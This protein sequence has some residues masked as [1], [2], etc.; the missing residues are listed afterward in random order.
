MTQEPDIIGS[1]VLL[2]LCFIGAIMVAALQLAALIAIL[3]TVGVSI[4]AAAHVLTL[5][6]EMWRNA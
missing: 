2:F 5:A 4:E 6:S 3:M 1:L